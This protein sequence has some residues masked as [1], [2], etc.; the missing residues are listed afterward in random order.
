MYTVVFVRSAYK[1]Y[2]KV[3][4]RVRQ[5]IDEVLQILCINPVSDVLRIRKIR[6]LENHYRIRVED[7]RIVYSPQHDKLIVR[8]IRVGH[9]RDVYD[10][11]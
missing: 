4:Q 5:R 1:E 11:F 2:R 10:H 6:G 3:P 8:V 9:R 7:Y